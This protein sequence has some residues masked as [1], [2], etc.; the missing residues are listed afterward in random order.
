MSTYCNSCRRIRQVYIFTLFRNDL[1]FAI[2]VWGGGGGGGAGALFRQN[3]ILWPRVA[4]YFN[5]THC[6]HAVNLS[7]INTITTT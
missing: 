2:S 3:K 6:D 5:T 4:T 1:P 7:Y